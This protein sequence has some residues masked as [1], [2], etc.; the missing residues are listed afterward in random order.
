MSENELQ[1]PVVSASQLHALKL[2][3]IASYI[4]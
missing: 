3:P 2:K 4:Y 1:I